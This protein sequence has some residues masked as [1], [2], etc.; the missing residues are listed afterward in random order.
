MKLSTGPSC[1]HGSWN[2]ARPLPRRPQAARLPPPLAQAQVVCLGEGLFGTPTPAFPEDTSARGGPTSL[3]GLRDV[4]CSGDRLP[5]GAEPT[6]T[7]R[8]RDQAVSSHSAVTVRASCR[9]ARG[10]KG[11]VQGGGRDLVRLPRWGA[12]QRSGRPGKAGHPCS[13]CFSSGEGQQGRRALHPPVWCATRSHSSN[14]QCRWTNGHPVAY[15]HR[16]MPAAPRTCACPVSRSS[17]EAT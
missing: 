14:K 1:R 13:L 10:P 6:P 3:R 8:S 17:L 2:C 16:I 9:H 15:C 4:V 5:S 12:L 11:Q 7:M